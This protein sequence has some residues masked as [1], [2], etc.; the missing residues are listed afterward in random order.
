MV[1]V[2]QMDNHQDSE[3]RPPLETDV[4]GKGGGGGKQLRSLLLTITNELVTRTLTQERKVASGTVSAGDQQ[5]K[6]QKS[7][8][9]GLKGKKNKTSESQ[10]LRGNTDGGGPGLVRRGRGLRW[11]TEGRR[12]RPGSQGAYF[13]RRSGVTCGQ[14]WGSSR[15]EPGPKLLVTND[16]T[17]SPFPF[18]GSGEVRDLKYLGLGLHKWK[19]R[20]RLS[21]RPLTRRG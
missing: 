14:G 13:S 11:T 1:G 4:Q 12:R 20:K 2:W 5:L 17:H 7:N 18:R 10:S 16:T 19:E 8:E 9:S 6:D 3:E 15:A 21:S